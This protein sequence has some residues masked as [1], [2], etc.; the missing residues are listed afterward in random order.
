MKDAG[1]ALSY[2]L[3]KNGDGKYLPDMI[4]LD[5]NL[6]VLNG[7]WLLSEMKKNKRL[8]DIP[9]FISFFLLLRCLLI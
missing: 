9:V 7:F 1:Q 4:L 5:L 6:P 8:K 3:G 2:M